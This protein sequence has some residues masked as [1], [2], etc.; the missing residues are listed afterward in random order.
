M[1]RLST[2]FK[3]TL[4]AA[5]SL[6]LLIVAVIPRAPIPQA[7]TL[8]DK[9]I[10]LIAYGVLC[11]LT[12][13]AWT[14]KGKNVDPRFTLAGALVYTGLMGIVTESLQLLVPGRTASLR[15][16]YAD[17]AGALLV[18]LYFRLKLSKQ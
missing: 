6:L 13:V 7:L 15:D 9:A 18:G 1:R 11:A 3:R 2:P 12:V 8:H 17:M 14:P 10:H 16:W 4:F 5:Y